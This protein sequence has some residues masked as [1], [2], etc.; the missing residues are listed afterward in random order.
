MILQ[1]IGDFFFSLLRIDLIRLLVGLIRYKYFSFFKNPKNIVTPYMTDVT[2][3]HNKSAFNNIKTDFIMNRIKYLYGPM[4]AI[5]R[6][7]R[8]SRILLIGSRTENEFLYFR[9]FNHKNIKAIDLMSY[10]PLIEIQDM[11]NLNF[12]DNT[13]DA[14]IMGWVLC[15]SNHPKKCASEITRVLKNDGIVAIGQEGLSS[16]LSNKNAVNNLKDIHNL[17][18]PSLNK[19]YFE[20]NAENSNLSETEIFKI[21]K[22]HSSHFITLF[23]I[24][25]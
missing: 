25:K 15:Y 22:F 7:N 3:A 19:I 4:S 10:S 6:I 13:F 24:K 18:N 1:K 20:Y 8:N 11:H 9:S 17:F 12:K 16:N 21:S 2:I 5:E 23:S 14:V